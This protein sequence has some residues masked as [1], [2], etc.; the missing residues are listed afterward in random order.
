[1]KTIA[2]SFHVLVRLMPLSFSDKTN[3]TAYNLRIQYKYNA[4]TI[5]K[6][7]INFEIQT[8]TF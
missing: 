5:G 7:E 4:S 1:M 3:L 6:V 8:A 2:L